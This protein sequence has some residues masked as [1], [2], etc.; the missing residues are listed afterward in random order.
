MPILGVLFDIDDTLVDHSTSEA[1][2]LLAHLRTEGLTERFSD[3]AT[4]LA[5]WRDIMERQYNRFLD[6]E[7]TYAEQQLER[8]REFL[9]HTMKSTPAAISDQEA[10]AWFARYQTHR[11]AAQSAFPDAEQVLRKL[12]ADYRLGVVSNSSTSR[13]R[14]KLDVF[15]LLSYFGDRLICSNEH[16]AAKPTPSIFLA[17]CAMLGLT[18]A[19]VVYVGDKY[20]IDAVGAHDAGLH[21]FW[22]DRANNRT[23]TVIVTGIHVIGSLDEL[24]D[25][26]TGPGFS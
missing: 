17:G 11:H 8:T 26:L 23:S 5:L 7:V 16:G 12:A 9:A 2:G 24:P 10:T 15:E 18:P 14:H 21:A 3:H 25:A 13:Q 22:L 19:E 4:A 20:E 1:A 6:G